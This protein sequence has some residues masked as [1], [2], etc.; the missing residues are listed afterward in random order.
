[1]RLYNTLSRQI[2]PFQPRGEEVT[3]YACGITPYDTTH[4]GHAFTYAAVDTLIRYLGYQEYEVQYVQNVTDVDDDILRQ[5]NQENTDWRLLGTLWTTHFI[6]DMMSLNVRPPDRFPRATDVIP[7]IILS[8]EAMLAAGVAYE[9]KGNVYFHVDAWPG[10]GRLCG[11][12][13]NEMLPIA[14]ER[15]N[16]PN[17]PGKRD[18]LDF[19]LWQAKQPG[20]PSWDSP[21][22]KGRPGWH[23]ECST[24]ATEL[25]GE[26]IDVHAGGHDLL[27]PHHECEVAQA[28]ATNEEMPFVRHWL[29]TA[30]VEHQGEKMSKSLGNLVMVR[31]LLKDYSP[32]AVRIYLAQ[33]HYRKA[34]SHDE[35]E[36]QKAEK[37][38]EKLK[39]AMASVDGGNQPVN[40]APV[41]KRFAAAMNNDLDTVRGVA[42]L[43]NL[44][45][46]ILFRASNGYRVAEAQSALSAMSNVFGLRLTQDLAEDCVVAGW[47]NHK[48]A[49]DN[50]R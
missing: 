27:F 42:S 22:G 35:V 16:H 6:E 31:D 46:E 18:P 11:I 32:D 13:R 14:N 45:D 24:L 33:H 39:A 50:N 21:W 1:M 19:V 4:L 5:A 41:K 37:R 9:S 34:W 2:E 43:L 3:V 29:H 23:I 17:D 28:E 8:V 7:Q 12:S 15:G 38:A 49:F 40:I 47:E 25:L 36:L 10:V 30:M 48:Q 44:A 26:T 20:E